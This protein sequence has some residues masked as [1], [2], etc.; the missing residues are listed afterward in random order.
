[1]SVYD[2]FF[3]EQAQASHLRSLVEQKRYEYDQDQRDKS[4]IKGE[5]RYAQNRIEKMGNEMAETQLLVKAMM[6]LMEEVEAFDSS[7]LIEKIKEIDLRDGVKD[8]RITPHG[9]RPK[10]KFKA[11]RNWKDL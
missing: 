7:R 1:M 10:P 3:P 2:F 8:G 6:E 9:S 5:L 4:D 11:K